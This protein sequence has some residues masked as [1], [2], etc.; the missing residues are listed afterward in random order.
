MF[1][2]FVVHVVVEPGWRANMR[3]IRDTGTKD[4]HTSALAACTSI[5]SSQNVTTCR[6]CNANGIHVM[7]FI[8]A[9]S[10]C[11]GVVPLR[12][13]DV[14]GTKHPSSFYSCPPIHNN[15]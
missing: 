11:P 13:L 10:K 12:L 2:P 1:R 6:E 14:G 15:E 8:E 3:R 5:L 9:E 4:V 7:A